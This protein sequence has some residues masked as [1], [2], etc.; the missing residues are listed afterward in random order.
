[1][2]GGCDGTEVTL[3][4]NIP[5]QTGTAPEYVR[6]YVCLNC[7]QGLLACTYK[8]VCTY[9]RTFTKFFTNMYSCSQNSSLV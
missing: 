3:A 6:M 5:A 8:Y 2:C 1:M 4:C 9:I 7:I